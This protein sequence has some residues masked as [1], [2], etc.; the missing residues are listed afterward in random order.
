MATTYDAKSEITTASA[1]AENKNLLTPKRKVTGK[2]T[3]TVVRVAERTARL[4][5]E[6]PASAATMGAAPCSSWREMF[7]S[8]MTELSMM[9]ENASASPPRIMVLIVLPIMYSTTKVASAESGIERNTA[10]VA[11]KL[12]RKMRIIRLVKASPMTPSCSRV[13]IASFTNAD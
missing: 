10:D 12:P 4:T 8:E 2:K 5:S 11:R 9:R 13:L 7:S 3:T 1:S 6:P